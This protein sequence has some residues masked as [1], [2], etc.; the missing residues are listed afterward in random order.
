MVPSQGRTL[1]RDGRLRRR[2]IATPCIQ[3]CAHQKRVRWL[4]TDI[5]GSPCFAFNERYT[6]NAKTLVCLDRHRTFGFVR[7]SR[8]SSGILQRTRQRKLF[9]ASRKL[10]CSSYEGRECS[11]F[12]SSS[13]CHEDDDP[14]LRGVGAATV[15]SAPVKVVSEK[16][17]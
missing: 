1:A 15:I 17:Q 14:S 3:I 16:W 5:I 7:Y 2:S 4:A 8:L 10:R 11:Q 6:R 9:P 12:S 13:A